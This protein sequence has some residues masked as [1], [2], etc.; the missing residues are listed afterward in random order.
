MIYITT[1]ILFLCLEKVL[2]S[3]TIQRILCGKLAGTEVAVEGLDGH[4]LGHDVALGRG[5][6]GRAVGTLPARVQHRAARQHLV[7]H[8]RGNLQTELFYV[9][10][11]CCE[12][13]S[14]IYGDI[15]IKRF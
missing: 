5:G 15:H 12:F 11:D 2:S 10:W 9:T 7:H 6:V 3:V 4:M 1:I 8:A 13:K 14:Q